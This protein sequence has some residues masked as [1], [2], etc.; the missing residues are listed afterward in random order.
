M[1]SQ[2]ILT[3]HRFLILM[4]QDYEDLEYWVPQ[5]PPVGGRSPRRSLPALATG[6]GSAASMAIRRSAMP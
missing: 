2:P 1:T 6:S 4:D 3:N 5:T